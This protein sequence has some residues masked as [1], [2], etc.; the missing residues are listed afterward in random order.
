MVNNEVK[1]TYLMGTDISDMGTCL[2][3]VRTGNIKIWI[4]TGISEA[5]L[6]HRRR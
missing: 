4:G 3:S 6:S 1:T 2:D 5:E